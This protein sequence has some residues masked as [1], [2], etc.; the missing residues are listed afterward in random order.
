M[1]SILGRPHGRCRSSSI[2]AALT[3]LF[4]P[5]GGRQLQV[6]RESKQR[7]AVIVKVSVD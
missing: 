7:D 2:R 6:R 3:P 4:Q 5:S 1:I